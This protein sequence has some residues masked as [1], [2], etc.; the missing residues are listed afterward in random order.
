MACLARFERGR[1]SRSAVLASPAFT[2]A[3]PGGSLPKE[4][5]ALYVTPGVRLTVNPNGL[6][7]AF[8]SLLVR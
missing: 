8:G 7:S 5:A 6:V 3:T 4:Y 2:V 1:L